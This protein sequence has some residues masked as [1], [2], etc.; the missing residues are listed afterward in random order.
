[1]APVFPLAEEQRCLDRVVDAGNRLSGAA[2]PSSVSGLVFLYRPPGEEA[3]DLAI[4]LCGLGDAFA[5]QP[6]EG[7]GVGLP[8]L[9]DQ[10]V[11]GVAL[12]GAV[13]QGLQ[14]DGLQ[15]PAELVA[16]ALRSTRART[17]QVAELGVRQF[18]ASYFNWSV[19]L[20]G[21]LSPFGLWGGGGVSQGPL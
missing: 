12:V 6:H 21:W 19:F 3:V 20:P 2:E 5:D 8:G 13:G 4:N 10:V 14:N 11:D 18:F 15:L 9:R 17:R 1:M 16:A 7:R